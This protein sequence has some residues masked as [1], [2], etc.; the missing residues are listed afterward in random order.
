V[1]RSRFYTAVTAS[2]A[3]NVYTWFRPD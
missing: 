1:R 2:K 3:Y